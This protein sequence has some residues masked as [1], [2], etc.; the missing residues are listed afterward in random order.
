ML[1]STTHSK[2][3]LTVVDIHRLALCEVVL[4]K[5]DLHDLENGSNHGW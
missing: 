5:P 2:Q 1:L 3:I 4:R